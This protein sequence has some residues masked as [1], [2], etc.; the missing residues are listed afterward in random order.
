MDNNQCMHNLM[1]HCYA[2]LVDQREEMD[3]VFH[4]TD[5][6]LLA[7]LQVIRRNTTMEAIFT[8]DYLRAY[9]S[10]PITAVPRQNTMPVA[11][12]RA[13]E[14]AMEDEDEEDD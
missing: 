7:G 13:Q 10:R 2:A 6:A 9:Y 14:N 5:E 3:H 8:M 12:A 11:A 1:R 4:L